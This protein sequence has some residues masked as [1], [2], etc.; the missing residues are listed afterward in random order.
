MSFYKLSILCSP[1]SLSVAIDDIKVVSVVLKES[2]IN[3][4]SFEKLLVAEALFDKSC[5]LL[6]KKLHK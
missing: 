5:L 6:N 1:F 3:E 2:N 4:V